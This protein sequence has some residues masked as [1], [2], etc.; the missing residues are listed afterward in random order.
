MRYP[1][2]PVVKVSP[3]FRSHRLTVSSAP[4][5]QLASFKLHTKISAEKLQTSLV[6]AI[7]QINLYM[8]LL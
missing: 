2:R 7:Y 1:H 3:V 8:R 5:G 4:D 6:A